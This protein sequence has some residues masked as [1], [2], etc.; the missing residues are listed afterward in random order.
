MAHWWEWLQRGAG[1]ASGPF[2]D[3]AHKGWTLVFR[4]GKDA[5]ANSLVHVVESESEEIGGFL[6]GR[7]E[8][9]LL[10]LVSAERHV[11]LEFWV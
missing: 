8:S 10:S 3:Y 5:L 1:N 4:V 11:H 2:S 6:V 7:S 9:V